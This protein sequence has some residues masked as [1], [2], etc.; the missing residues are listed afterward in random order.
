M[1]TKTLPFIPERKG[2]VGGFVRWLRRPR[3]VAIPPRKEE[4]PCCMARRDSLGRPPLGFCSPQ[5]L[6]RPS[7]WA[8]FLE[9]GGEL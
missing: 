1:R 5:C 7:V 3:S 8:A 4:A 9:Q 6:R 2:K